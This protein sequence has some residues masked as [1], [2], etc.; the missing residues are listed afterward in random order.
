MRKTKHTVIPRAHCLAYRGARISSAAGSVSTP[1][2]LRQRQSQT[3]PK[4][5]AYCRCLAVRLCSESRR[6]TAREIP[7]C[8]AMLLRGTTSAE[9]P[10]CSRTIVRSSRP[11]TIERLVALFLSFRIY[12]CLVCYNRF[13]VLQR[14]F[15]PTEALLSAAT[16]MG[17]GLQVGVKG[18]RAVF[19]H[20][21]SVKERLLMSHSRAFILKHLR[22]H[23]QSTSVEGHGNVP[24]SSTPV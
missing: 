24:R 12:R 7:Y 13:Y 4:N 14:Q 10:Q 22:P 6:A 11:R 20:Q 15:R 21:A 16:K 19:L 9:C 23:S 1:L 5:I 3:Y 18:I 8:R 17:H 2:M